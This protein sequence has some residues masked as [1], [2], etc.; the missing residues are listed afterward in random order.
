[1]TTDLV[2][3]P[4]DHRHGDRLT[5]TQTALLDME[6]PNRHMHVGG[7]FIFEPGPDGFT[8]TALDRL[9]RARLHRVPRH[10]QRL[11][12]APFGIG[13]PIW[14][15]DAEF[16]LSYHVRHTALPAPGG[17]PELLDFAA[18]M[19]AR[20]LDR[21]RPLFQVYLVDGLEGGRT[22]LITKTHQALIEAIHGRDLVAELLDVDVDGWKAD[23]TERPHVAKPIPSTLALTS[24]ALLDV[25]SSPAELVSATARVARAPGRAAMSAL[26]V[27]RGIA[28]LATSG[29]RAPG[30]AINAI[31]GRHRRLA[32]TSIPLADVKLVKDAFHTT[33]NDVVLAIVSD[34]TGRL[35]R[36]H[37]ERTDGQIVR[38]MVPVSTAERGD[39]HELGNRIA[40]VVV[41]LP[42]EE[43]DPAERL[44][45]CRQAMSEV[46]Q[47]HRAVGAGFIMDMADFAPAAL[48]SAA[49]RLASASKSYNFMV[50]NVPGPRSRRYVLGAPLVAAY[51]FTPLGPVQ[52][53]AVGVTS[54]VDSM[55]I[56]ITADWDALPDVAAV[57]GFLE[58]SLRELVEHAGAVDARGEIVRKHLAEP[59]R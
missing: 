25:V 20:P 51:P 5:S 33:V 44:D 2:H 27:T 45:V 43:M 40:S 23:T 18:R 31:P 37:G 7:V 1:M 46:R 36:L 13:H 39:A 48:H 54:L 53:Y 10:R 28:S 8:F 16:D 15:D 12:A 3:S 22:A 59:T 47:E 57:P 34:A 21:R 38:V 6:A 29:R 19:F 14:V 52:A 4:T 9:I 50:T 26:R 17:M 11:A 41:A 55:D 58:A 42:V 30:T 35:L 49:A 24:Q 32:A 56:G